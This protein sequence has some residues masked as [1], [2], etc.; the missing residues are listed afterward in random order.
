MA[1]AENSGSRIDKNLVT[2]FQEDSGELRE[3]I[4]EVNSLPPQFNI[5][6]GLNGG[7]WPTTKLGVDENEDL[8]ASLTNLN[9]QLLS[10]VSGTTTILH[11]AGAIALRA[12]SQ[13][14]KGFI[15]NPLVKAMYANREL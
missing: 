14:V 2:W 8:E 13:Q 1:L 3:L 10:I 12:T 15:D 4:V 7:L 5:E 6:R 9:A 11:A